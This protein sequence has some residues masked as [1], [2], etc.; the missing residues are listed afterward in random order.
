M[1]LNINMIDNEF[2][3]KP[4]P[5]DNQILK[6]AGSRQIPS[7]DTDTNTVTNDDFKGEW[8]SATTYAIGDLAENDGA[9]YICTA[10]H[11]NQEPPNASYWTL[12]SSDTNTLPYTISEDFTTDPSWTKT[13]SGGTG[14]G[15][16]SGGFVNGA[17]SSPDGHALVNDSAGLGCRGADAAGG[18]CRPGP[19]F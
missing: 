2:V 9:L 6:S 18:R 1:G 7:D 19:G 5:N 15:V 13:D 16:S 11:S 3:M 10:A 14:A 4:S 17:T 8:S 12:M